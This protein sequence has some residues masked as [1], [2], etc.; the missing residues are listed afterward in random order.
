MKKVIFILFGILILNTVA[1]AQQVPQKFSYQG[2]VRDASD[3]LLADQVVNFKFTI[4]GD[5]LGQQIFYQET[6]N[7]STNQYGMVNL[8]IGNGVVTSGAFSAI[9]WGSQQIYF[10]IDLDIGSGFIP[11]GNQEL[12]SVPYALYSLSTLPGPTGPTGLP[13]PT[14]PSGPV[15]EI[16]P[17]GIQGNTGETGSPGPTGADGITGS[18]GLPGQNGPTGPTGQQGTTGSSGI[19]GVTG[20]TGLQGLV[21]PTGSPGSPGSTGAQGLQGIQGITGQTG[22][23]GADGSIGSQ[24]ATGPTGPSGSNGQTGATGPVGPTG[25]IITIRDCPSGFVPVNDQYCIQA[26]QNTQDTWWNAV[27]YCYSMGARL[28]TVAEIYYGC[29]N[30]LTIP[31]DSPPSGWTDDFGNGAMNAQVY[32]SGC[33]TIQ[34][35][36]T[37]P[38]EFR[39]CSNR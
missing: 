14:G 29:N 17:Q 33:I 38:K 7:T 10:L 39:C 28:C 30:Y 13:G 4:A 8:F 23:T 35:N 26:N 2:V 22:P 6:Q 12:V 19:N 1:Y 16:G 21:G 5:I 37:L 31:L 34:S 25:G 24:G 11:I 36:T 3:N 9:P 18:T 27:Q 15:G 20:P 32:T